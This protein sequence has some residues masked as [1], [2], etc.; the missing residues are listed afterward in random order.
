MQHLKRMR[1]NSLH[2]V[3]TV[4][5]LLFISVNVKADDLLN[6]RAM[7]QQATARVVK[8]IVIDETG[9][10]VIGANVLVKGSS[11]GTITNL[12]GEFSL[13]VSSNKTILQVSYIGF[14]PIEVAVKSND[15]LKIVLKED[16]LLLNEVVVVGYNSVKKSQLTGALKVVKGDELDYMS[17]PTLEN[18]LQGKTPGVMVSSG[19]GQ[20][21]S[22]NLK[23]RIRGTGS[24]NGSNTPLYIMD[25]VMVEPAQFAALNTNDIADLQVLKDASATAIY[26]SRGANGVIV[27]TT[28][29]GS[30]GKT[31]INYRNQFGFSKNR[32]YLEMMNNE[33]NIQ[34]QLQCAQSD[35]SS[36]MYPL[37]GI[38]RKEA[39]GTAS[40][41]DL[42]RL[43]LARATN[44][45][46]IDEMTQTGFLMEHSVDVSGGSDKTKFYISGSYL[47]QAG[48]LKNAGLTRYS[49]RFNIDHTVNKY[50]SLG[51]KAS[52]GYGLV[53]F[54]DPGGGN[55]RISWLNPW[56]TTLLA[57]P[58]ESPD[59]WYNKDNPTYITKYFKQK[60]H[61]VKA[62][63]SGYAKVNVL[64]WL[65]V[66]TNFGMDYMYNRSI[67]TVDRNHPAVAS[68][69]GEFSQSN[70][71]LLRYT[72]TNTLNVNKDFDNGHSLNAVAGM[73]MF[74]GGYY[75][76]N[77]RGND[78]NPDLSNT[79]NGIGDKVGA[80]NNP[81]SVGGTSTKSNLF[82][83]FSQVGYGIGNKYNFSASLRHDTSSKFHG[84]NKSAIFWSVGGAWNM[85]YE[86]FLDDVEWLNQLKY[87]ISYGTTGNQ[88]G[89]GDFTT[90]DGYTN[91]SYN[92]ET[93]YVH[94]Q[95]GN[96][97]LKWEKSAQFNTGIDFS[98]FN[99][100]LNA[101]LDY[102][103]IKT[104]DL[105]MSKSIS[106]TSGFGSLLTNAGSVVNTGV[107]ISLEG[108]VIR[109]KDFRWNLSANFTYNKNKINDLG[110][111]SNADNRFEVGN[112][113][114]EVGKPLGTWYMREWGG[115]DPDTGVV[116]YY[117]EDGNKTT[118]EPDG[119]YIE[120]GTSEVPYFGG[121]GTNF[122]W[123]G[124]S[125]S[126][127]FTYAF[128]YTI[129]N[130]GRWFVDNHNFN[131]NKPRYML[132]MWME[133]G[134][135]TDIPRF[136]SG[137]QPSPM[138]SQF[139][140]DAS[141]L[142]L[143]TVRL[144]YRLPKKLVEK[145]KILNSVSV[146]LQGE[147]LAVWT[148]YRGADPEVNGD[149]DQL[150]YPKPRNITFGFDI[151]F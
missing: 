39:N 37:M 84:N 128:N 116:F 87:R 144:N 43:A 143:K 56:F 68:V 57:Y 95:L 129:M 64:D 126:A 7:P 36:T 30:S 24:I 70:S 71:D 28:K 13:E 102:Y 127:D 51:V 44:T 103:Y 3:L 133:P 145:T 108:D 89:I 76:S 132:D 86:N 38:L 5:L 12:D 46:W 106:S 92:G 134:D 74:Q 2:Y 109:T 111:W 27:I 73:E 139:L 23:V 6:E 26:G 83:W 35:P 150:S 107:E 97:G 42:E 85:H 48:T 10:P 120:K 122:S 40:E 114:F 93:G 146:Y 81:P 15:N 90:F 31:K 125:L 52:A 142:R 123:K 141:Y 50:L 53:T 101:T 137:T 45:N 41:Q 25:G 11:V 22:D 117:D 29:T 16:A 96:A 75:A 98:L 60:Q 119:R 151:N 113:I 99:N 77:F 130:A 94:G 49:G 148:K 82:S 115:V 19:S 124:L 78:V 32:D 100:R 147:N 59:D 131:G 67:K 62:V 1:C 136:L 17:S 69:K 91:S 9:F 104:N 121:F 66:K 21:G 55:N 118:N 79:P 65:S 63:W 54:S 72:W 135:I 88:D 34:Y 112:K 33:E 47:D 110:I 14:T 105:L 58:Y 138:A 140:E 149:V 4:L 80:S 8:G 61:K 18:R 20:P